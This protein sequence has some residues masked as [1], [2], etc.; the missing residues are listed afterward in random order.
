MPEIEPGVIYRSGPLTS[1]DYAK[2]ID[3]LCGAQLDVGIDTLP[4]VICW[5]EEHAAK[6]CMH[7]ALVVARSGVLAVQHAFWRCFHCGDVFRLDQEAEAREHFGANEDVPAA[8]Q[9]VHDG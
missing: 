3:E 8:C 9:R 4:C 5:G 2:A 7:N 6:D 1:D